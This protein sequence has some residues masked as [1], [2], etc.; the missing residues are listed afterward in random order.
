MGPTLMA[1]DMTPNLDESSFRAINEDRLLNPPRL[2]NPS[3]SRV[4]YKS[5]WV[6]ASSFIASARLVQK[7]HEGG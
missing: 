3:V 4:R 5:L 1:E 2:F 6:P 7:S